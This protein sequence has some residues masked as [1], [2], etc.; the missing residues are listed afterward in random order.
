MRDHAIILIVDDEMMIRFDVASHAQDAGF[1]AVEAS[2]AEE[3][4]NLMCDGLVPDMLLTDIEMPGGMDGLSLAHLVR[5]RNPN[6]VIIVASGRIMPAARD[7]PS[8]TRFL[9]KPFTSGMLD[10]AFGLA[11]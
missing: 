4:I 7:M 6:A 1:E 5:R 3:A 9:A 11:A 8:G 2:S 10:A